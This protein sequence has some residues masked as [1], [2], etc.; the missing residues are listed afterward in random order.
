ML[1]DILEDLFCRMGPLPFPA[2]S[3]GAADN[4]QLGQ[5]GFQP[6][7]DSHLPQG[8]VKI[9]T[10]QKGIAILTETKRLPQTH[11]DSAAVKKGQEEAPPLPWE[12]SPAE[13]EEHTAH[14][15]R[16]IPPEPRGKP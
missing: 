2:G 11:M 1:V 7:A 16:P 10:L 3:S 9:P 15:A 6:A 13:N 14:R 4:G 5:K 12:E 8:A